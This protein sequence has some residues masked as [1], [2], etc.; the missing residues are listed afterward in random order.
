V[1]TIGSRRPGI[2]TPGVNDSPLHL[3]PLELPEDCLPVRLDPGT[4]DGFFAFE[5]ERRGA[6]VLAVDYMPPERTA[7][8][9]GA[10]SIARRVSP[11]ES[12]RLKP[13]TSAHSISCCFSASCITCRIPS[14]APHRSQLSRS[15]W[16][17]NADH[18]PRDACLRAE[19]RRERR[20]CLTSLPMML[21]FPTAGHGDHEPLGSEY[22]LR[23]SHAREFAVERVS[24]L[25]K[26]AIFQRGR[27][28]PVNRAHPR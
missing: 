12:L 19:I 4:R 2:V 27:V 22:P 20:R 1:G 28:A 16:P 17:G 7:S 23:R 8:D 14:G 5:M 9:R 10:A 24:A 15:Q 13:S 26:R 11:R 6:E 21:F 18:R 25:V 3:V